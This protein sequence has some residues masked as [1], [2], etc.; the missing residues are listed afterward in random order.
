M[1]KQFVY[2]FGGGKD[3][4]HGTFVAAFDSI[5]DKRNP[6]SHVTV[7]SGVA[8]GKKNHQTTHGEQR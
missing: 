8:A 1:S 4:V 6:C 2:F 7:W 5:F 3:L